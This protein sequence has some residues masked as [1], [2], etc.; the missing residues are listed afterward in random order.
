M[1]VGAIAAA[2]AGLGLL[3]Y[4]MS[5]H[6]RESFTTD[7]GGINFLP[8]LGKTTGKKKFVE[9]GE[10][11]HDPIVDYRYNQ[12]VNDPTNVYHPETG[13]LLF[14]TGAQSDADGNPIHKVWDDSVGAEGGYKNVLI[15]PHI[16]RLPHDAEIR[17]TWTDM[18]NQ[19]SV[20][21]KDK[22]ETRLGEAQQKKLDDIRN[23]KDRWRK[24]AE[25]IGKINTGPAFEYDR[26]GD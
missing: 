7:E 3:G 13:N 10:S 25:G 20:D 6:G 22:T 14:G 23:K 12:S 15:P 9:E 17:K 1:G 5:P 21:Q 24:L 16:A 4:G 2:I 8:K 18:H 19:I 11:L 26:I